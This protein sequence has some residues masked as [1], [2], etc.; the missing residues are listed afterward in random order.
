MRSL[1]VACIA[2]L[3][4][5]T[6]CKD[7]KKNQD[8]LVATSADYPPYEFYIDGK[9]TGYEIEL[10]HMIA[11]E[12]GITLKFNDMPF[13]SI[14]GALQAKR[15]DLAV[16]AMSATTERRLKVDFADPHHESQSVMLVDESSGFKTV[17][18]LKNVVIGVQMGTAY[19][20]QLNTKLLPTLEGTRVQT[21]SKVPDLIQDFKAKRIH[22]IMLGS[23]DAA[24]IAKE[25][26]NL[27]KIPVPNTHVAYAIALQKDSPLT[28]KVNAA[29]A[30]FKANGALKQ[31]EEKWVKKHDGA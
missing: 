30:K 20:Q 2:C 14:L 28:P 26:K 31:L 23:V 3:L 24:D 10:M 29:L 19:E 18:D 22:A 27:R 16:A 17:G 13:D 9:M 12:I 11:G 1:I 4:S 21:L 5:V 7:D 8:Y 25:V 6:A 15:T